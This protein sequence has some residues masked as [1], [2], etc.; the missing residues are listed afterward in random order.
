MRILMCLALAPV[1]MLAVGGMNPVI[2]PAP[3]YTYHDAGI[4]HLPC[5]LDIDTRQADAKLFNI[6]D[7]SSQREGKVTCILHYEGPIHPHQRENLEAIGADIAGYLPNYA[8]LVR[9]DAEIATEVSSLTGLD[10]IGVYEPSYKLSPDIDSGAEEFDTFTVIIYEGSTDRRAAAVVEELGGEVITSIYGDWGSLLRIII[11]PSLLGEIAHDGSVKWIELY[12]QPHI[13][14][15]SAQWVVQTWESGNRRIWD[16]GLTGKGQVISWIDSGLKASHNFFRDP[17][18]SISGFDNYPS[19]RK[20]IAYVKSFSDPFNQISYGDENGHG[21]HTGGSLA[22]NDEPV[23]G[24][25]ANIGMAPDAKLYALDG[26]GGGSGIIT[27][28]NLEYS[29][30]IPYEGNSAG[31]ARIISLSW[32]HQSTRSY[33]AMCVFV[34][35]TVWRRPDYLILSSAGNTSAGTYTG[36]P[37]NAKNI[38]GVGG[39][40][41]AGAAFMVW[42]GSSIGPSGDGRIKPDLVVPGKDVRSAYATSNDAEIALSG[43]SMASPVAAGNAAL[44]R[45]YFTDGY[46]PTGTPSYQAGFTPSA[47]LLKATLINSVETDYGSNHVPDD[48]VGWGRPN[49]DNALYFPGDARK[50]VVADYDEGL[51]TGTQFT[52]S[53]S[54]EADDVPLRITVCWMD[55]PAV[56]SAS[57]ALVNDLNL[58]VVSPSGKTYRGNNFSENLSVEDGNYDVRNT[59]ENVFVDSPEEGEWSIHVHGNNV[60]IGPQPFALVV[61]GNIAGDFPSIAFKD[62]TVDDEGQSNPDGHMDPGEEVSVSVSLTNSGNGGLTNVQASLSTES[63]DV[64]VTDNSSNYGSINLGQTADGDGFEISVSA[65]AE[66]D[67]EIEFQVD[68][69]ADD[70]SSTLNFNLPVGAPRY[71]WTTHDAGNVRLT[72]S[73]Q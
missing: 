41:N 37:A 38:I 39:C 1:A 55:F 33:D 51:E 36:S 62:A 65:S 50:L 49:L 43:T 7:L 24:S 63:G 28:P 35:K 59:V 60:P 71:E 66:A 13:M 45:Q 4:I 73:E 10:W 32:G 27:H 40:Q 9:M 5:G 64:T 34:D 67:S 48:N 30:A 68:I 47:A 6:S 31:A 8:Y 72:V 20:V 2:Q 16:E 26:G 14:N 21:T 44:V 22:G 52:G 29:L 23:G 25:S 61:T 42:N 57:P 46:Y 15:A 18:L 11:S 53:V 19:H 12:N 69:S 3:T 17:D 54:V 58:E 70:Y 56:E